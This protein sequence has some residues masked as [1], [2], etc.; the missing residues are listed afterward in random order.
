MHMGMIGLG[1]M[2]TNDVRRAKV[3]QYKGIHNV[4]VGTSGGVWGLE[5]GYCMLIGG[6]KDLRYDF[7][8]ADIAEVWRRG[9][10]ENS[11]ARWLPVYSAGTSAP[12]AADKLIEAD[13]RK[14]RTL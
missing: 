3:L 4:D 9:S 14:W 12:V 10:W 1:R 2:G 13:N 8:M 7:D 11:S 6:S 5:R